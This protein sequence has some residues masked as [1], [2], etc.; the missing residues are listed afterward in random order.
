MKYR[1]LLG[2][3]CGLL[4]AGSVVA[5]QNPPHNEPRVVMETSMGKV[6]IALE[7][8]RAPKTVANFLTYVQDG[9]YDGSVFHRVIPGFVVQGG[10][11]NADY[12]SLPAHQPVENE[13][14]GGM[15]NL[16]GTIAMARTPQ[17]DSATRQ[18]YFNL[19]DN[20]ALDGSTSQYGYTVFGTV[21]EGMDV[22]MA[23]AA[24]PTGMESRIGA[25][26]VPETPIVLKHI[27]VKR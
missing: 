24:Q 21:V 9:S 3:L 17:P 10:G 14:K 18:F 8:G 12:Q 22:I 27:S 1:L 23:M 5:Q 7:P 16:K 25:T 15:S 13:S 11:Y 2:M 26:D 6:V 20:Q 19:K 4:T